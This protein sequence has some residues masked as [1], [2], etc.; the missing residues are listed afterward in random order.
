MTKTEAIKELEDR[1]VEFDKS[2]SSADIK[3]LLKEVIKVEE[4]NV[5]NE[6][7]DNSVNGQEDLTIEADKT[8]DPEDEENDTTFCIEEEEEEDTD[9]EDEVKP[10]YSK[11]KK[12]ETG[13]ITEDGKTHGSVHDAAKHAG[14]L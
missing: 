2:L 8:V 7:E 3:N 12:I 13:W 14:S 4:L 10:N 6:L 11:V 9:I 1:G 5:E